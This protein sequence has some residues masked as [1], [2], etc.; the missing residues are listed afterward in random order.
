MR[1]IIVAVITVLFMSCNEQK[2]TNNFFA[3]GEFNEVIPMDT[4]TA[5]NFAIPVYN[6]DQFEKLLQKKSK[7]TYVVNFWATWCKPCVKELPS[8]EKLQR[9][10]NRDG[11]E[12]ILVSL[13]FPKKAD[14]VLVPFLEKKNFRNQVLLLDDP[15]QNTWIP[16]VDQN[17]SGAIPATIIFNEKK[18][19]FYEKS[20]TFNELEAEVKKFVD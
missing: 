2:K 17:W 12:V 5:N 14:K 11:V 1:T 18:R 7:T 8:F 19:L 9:K 6:F 15:K 4:L 3:L 16:K 10:Y 13:D 20:F